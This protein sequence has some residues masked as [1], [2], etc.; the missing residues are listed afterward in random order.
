MRNNVKYLSTNKIVYNAAALG[1]VLDMKN[2]KQEFFDAHNEDITALAMHPN[3]KYIA[4]S[5]L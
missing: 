5:E 1:I 4:T 3:G 2:N